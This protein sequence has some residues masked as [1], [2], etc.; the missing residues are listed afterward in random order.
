MTANDAG[1]QTPPVIR[2]APLG[3][4]NV[5]SVY[6]HELET[7]AEGSSASLFLNFALALLPTSV[8]LMIALATTEIAARWLFDV[9]VV[10]CAVT[11]ISGVVLLALWWQQ[12][13]KSRRTMELIKNRMPPPGA[14]Q[15]TAN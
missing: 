4:L 3:E 15:E 9:F 8:T 5:Y 13:K 10:V 7:L 6:E 14:I 11:L 12:R 2:R 1:G